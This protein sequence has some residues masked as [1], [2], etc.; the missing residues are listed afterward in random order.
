MKHIRTHKR[1]ESN[2]WFTQSSRYDLDSL[3]STY[4]NLLGYTGYLAPAFRKMRENGYVYK[5]FGK[6]G[7]PAIKDVYNRK[8]DPEILVALYNHQYPI[9]F[10]VNQSDPKSHNHAFFFYESAKQ[11][12]DIDVRNLFNL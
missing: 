3:K 7:Y 1:L 9:I 10:L 12:I 2:S 5:D 8:D 4:N 11:E 6:Y